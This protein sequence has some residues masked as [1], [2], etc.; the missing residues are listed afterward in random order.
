MNEP[1]RKTIVGSEEE[2]SNRVSKLTN[3]LDGLQREHSLLDEIVM[4]SEDLAT[5]VVLR[6]ASLERRMD[7]IRKSVK[8]LINDPN[9][10]NL[11][12]IFVKRSQENISDRLN[13]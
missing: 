13:V 6:M 3:E 11:K 2:L 4:L 12:N 8:D 7:E 9:K 10:I 5:G 1:D